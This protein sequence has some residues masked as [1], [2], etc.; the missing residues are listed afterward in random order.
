MPPHPLLLNF[1][2]TCRQKQTDDYPSPENIHT[3]PHL[4]YFYT[5]IWNKMRP[6]KKQNSQESNPLAFDPLN[7]LLGRSSY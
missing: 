5:T 4:M 7:S 1:P 3:Y 2:T 6:I